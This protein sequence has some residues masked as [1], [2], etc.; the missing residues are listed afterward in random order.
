MTEKQIK[1]TGTGNKQLKIL[2]MIFLI[3]KIN[4]IPYPIIP[5]YYYWLKLLK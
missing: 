4:N 1:I 5:Y 3:L 2:E